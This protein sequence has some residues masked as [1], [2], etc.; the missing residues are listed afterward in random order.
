MN[1]ICFAT[2]LLF[3]ATKYNFS[4]SAIY[5]MKARELTFL[6]QS[7][8]H[9]ALTK[10]LA[11]SIEPFNNTFKPATVKPVLHLHQQPAIDL[12]HKIVSPGRQKPALHLRLLQPF[13][14]AQY[15]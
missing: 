6:K 9:Y 11:K 1:T 3:S 8:K 15:F 10:L 7:L 13:L 12:L 5:Y 2:N 4:D 14:I